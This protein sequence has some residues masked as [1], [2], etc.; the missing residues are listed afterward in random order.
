[1]YYYFMALNREK[2]YSAIRC[3][4]SAVSIWLNR[5]HT[6]RLGQQQ[7]ACILEQKQQLLFPHRRG[8]EAEA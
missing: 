5:V 8:F 4:A 7:F 6:S 2:L 1:M 3:F